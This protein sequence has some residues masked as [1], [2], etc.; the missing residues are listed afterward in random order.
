M[1]YYLN[2]GIRLCSTTIL[3]PLVFCIYNVFSI[4]NGLIYYQQ[5]SR[6]THLQIIFVVI[7]TAILLSGV[8]S[9]SWRLSPEPG[10]PP[11]TPLAPNPFASA[12]PLELFA[13]DYCDD[14]EQ[15]TSSPMENRRSRVLSLVEVEGLKDL[16][17]DIDDDT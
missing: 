8:L 4:L 14:V 10:P 1:L 16:L 15:Q 6:L 12:P 13:D 11:G 9:L 3:Y 5:T 17:G 2:S 7:G